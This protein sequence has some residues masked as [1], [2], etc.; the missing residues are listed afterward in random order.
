MIAQGKP[1]AITSLE[2]LRRVYDIGL[3]VAPVKENFIYRGVRRKNLVWGKQGTFLALLIFGLCVLGSVLKRATDVS[4]NGFSAMLCKIFLFSCKNFP[5]L[6]KAHLRF[7][8]IILE[9]A[10][11]VILK[12]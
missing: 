6:L 12:I 7:R 10:L 1:K 8:P 11:R 2:I 5:T 9:T 3:K 4:F